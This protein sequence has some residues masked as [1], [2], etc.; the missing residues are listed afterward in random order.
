MYASVG[1][2]SPLSHG[3]LMI[4]DESHHETFYIIVGPEGALWTML[5]ADRSKAGVA[6]YTSEDLR[7]YCDVVVFFQLS[8]II[9]SPF[10]RGNRVLVDWHI[11]NKEIDVPQL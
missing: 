6:K 1:L 8:Q 9:P 3:F 5:N 4:L 10:L 2:H 7:C 11:V